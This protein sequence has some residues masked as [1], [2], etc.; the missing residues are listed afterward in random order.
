MSIFSMSGMGSG[1]DSAGAD[2]AGAAVGSGSEA[3][4]G[5][6]FSVLVHFCRCSDKP[7]VADVRATGVIKAAQ[8]EAPT[9]TGQCFVFQ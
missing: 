9:R 3:K 7:N 8:D 6:A 2:S 1:V 5:L 4:N